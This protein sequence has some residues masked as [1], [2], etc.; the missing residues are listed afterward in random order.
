[1]KMKKPAITISHSAAVPLKAGK[2]KAIRA[3]WRGT[4]ER[5]GF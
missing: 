3:C 1:M 4:D 5:P 2:S